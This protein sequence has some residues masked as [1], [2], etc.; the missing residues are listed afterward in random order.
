MSDYE[1]IDLSTIC[2]VPASALSEGRDPR[3]GEI[4]C[5]GLPFRVGSSSPE[6]CF[7]APGEQL[8][9]VAVGRIVRTVLFAHTLHSS[10]LHEGEPP[11]KEV[12]RL[13]FCLSG[14]LRIETPIRERF[15][16]A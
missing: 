11:G 16:V 13:A 5:R 14:G 3:I 1:P 15:E 10:R 2:T 7:V 8:V 4:S 9:V 6:R 12:A